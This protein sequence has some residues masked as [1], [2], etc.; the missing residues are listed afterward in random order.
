MYIEREGLRLHW[1]AGF[2]I[3]MGC[4]VLENP[5]NRTQIIQNDDTYKMMI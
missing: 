4:G 2:T 5:I 3:T 1:G